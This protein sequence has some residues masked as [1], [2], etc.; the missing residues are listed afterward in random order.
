MTQCLNYV[1]ALFDFFIYYCCC[2]L[3]YTE[4][5]RES[6]K[7]TGRISCTSY[8]LHGK[9]KEIWRREEVW[10]WELNSVPAQW[11]YH[12]ESAEWSEP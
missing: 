11:L 8:R 3:G 7:H 5:Q 9:K 1:T 6:R 10:L 4:V 12:G 2:F